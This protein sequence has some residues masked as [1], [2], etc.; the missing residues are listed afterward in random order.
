MVC[1]DAAGWIVGI[2]VECVEMGTDL[3]DGR[4][5][6]GHAGACFK[7]TTLG[8]SW[9][10]WDSAE[11]GTGAFSTGGHFGC[12]GFMACLGSSGIGLNVRTCVMI[13]GMLHGKLKA[14]EYLVMIMI[15]HWIQDGVQSH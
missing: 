4:E 1:L 9:I 14:D 3:L 11:I 5:V 12:R 6:L 2:D 13:L 7:D 8:C 15:Q 10:A